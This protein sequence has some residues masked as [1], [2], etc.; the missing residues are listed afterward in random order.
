MFTQE[1]IIEVKSP[2]FLPN[3]LAY[4]GLAL[5]VALSGVLVGFNAL[6]SNPQILA[7]SG[8]FWLVIGVEIALAWTA[9][10]WSRNLPLGYWMFAAFAF[11]TGLT[12]VPILALAG[13][14]G[15][16]E[17]ISRALI[18]SVATFG[19]AALF[20]HV[21]RRNLAGLNGFLMMCLLSVFVISIIGIFI[22]W[23]NTMEI[24]I[25][26]FIVLLFSGF[27]MHDI[28]AIQRMP[29]ISPLLAATLLFIDFINIF[30]GLLRL[31]IAL[32][33]D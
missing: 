3:T 1:S 10:K 19:A 4:F 31:L 14:V 2:N 32:R 6:M 5:L 18:A 22:P 8:I 7:N 28:Q 23:N 17:I 29:G 21:T 33:R 30:V 9:H 20:G 12:T 26:G 24:V 27:T 25:S 15:G 13:S 16:V 11:L